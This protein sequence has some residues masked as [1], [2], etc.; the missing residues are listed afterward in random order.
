MARSHTGR[1]LEEKIVQE[2]QKLAEQMALGSA[3]DFETYRYLCGII[4]GRRD[5]L[6]YLDEL[7]R[8]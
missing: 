8:D 5:A 2:N 1:L 6:A 3:K 4:E 7:E